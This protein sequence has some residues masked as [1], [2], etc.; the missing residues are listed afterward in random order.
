MPEFVKLE[1]LALN[2][3][4]KLKQEAK[5]SWF[6]MLREFRALIWQNYFIARQRAANFNPQQ[7]D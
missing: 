3:V 7:M 1:N 2:A 5:T 4:V 6:A